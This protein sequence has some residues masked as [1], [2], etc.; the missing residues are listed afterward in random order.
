MNIL[1]FQLFLCKK[2]RKLLEQYLKIIYY[3]ILSGSNGRTIYS[4]YFISFMDSILYTKRDP[5]TET[6]V[7]HT[8]YLSHK[9]I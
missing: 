5:I 6:Y 7:C 9:R 4:L 3:G 2:Y 1:I 8:H